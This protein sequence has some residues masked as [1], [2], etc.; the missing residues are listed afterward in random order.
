VALK[1][2]RQRADIYHFHD[3]ELLPV[4]ILL[5]LLGRRVIYDSHEDMPRAIH[6]KPYLARVLRTSIGRVFELFENWCARRFDA[7]VVVTEELAAR[8]TAV[9]AR[10]VDVA[11]YPLLSDFPLPPEGWDKE[12][13]VCFVGGITRIRGILEIIDA[14]DLA[15][16]R[17]ILAGEF[18]SAELHAEAKALPGWKC[19]EE[20][21][22]VSRAE[23]VQ[24]MRRSFAGLVLY[25]PEPNHLGAQPNKLFE[26]MAA[27]LPVIASDFP[28]WRRIVENAGFGVVVDPYDRVRIAEEIRKL[29]DD[30]ERAREMGAR[31]RRAVEEIYNW[32]SQYKKLRVL[33]ADI[34]GLRTEGTA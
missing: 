1:V 27:G 32:M 14:A 22:V 31:G 26:Y 8:F 25:Y 30:P 2:V 17:L 7:V 9:G 15:G 34:A 20:L 3:P 23:T 18:N 5:K 33:Y 29:R 4:G 19:V 11:N 6:S 12:N 13:A 16:V 24:V 21:G 28:R 10:S